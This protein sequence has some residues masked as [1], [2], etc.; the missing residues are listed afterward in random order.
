MTAFAS[1]CALA[2]NTNTAA[3]NRAVAPIAATLPP[4]RAVIIALMIVISSKIQ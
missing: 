1:V 2:G 3:V 4:Y